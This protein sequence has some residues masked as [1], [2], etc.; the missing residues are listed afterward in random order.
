MQPVSVLAIQPVDAGKVFICHLAGKVRDPLVL[1]VRF[2]LCFQLKLLRAGEF[3]FR[4]IHLLFVR[5]LNG[6]CLCFCFRCSLP[7]FAVLF[8]EHPILLQ[9]F[10]CAVQRDDRLALLL[11]LF[12]HHQVF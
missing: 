6:F 1:L 7:Q 8:F 2:F 12:L 11:Q 3:L 4:F 10:V 5:C 9:H